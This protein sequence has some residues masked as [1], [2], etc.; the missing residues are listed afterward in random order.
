MVTKFITA[1]EAA[2]LKGVSR[3]AIYA[4][5]RDGRLTSKELL[6]RMAL[7]EA[8]VLAW[9]PAPRSGRKK[10][11]PMSDEAKLKISNGQRRRWAATR[12]S[13]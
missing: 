6:G 9:T 8:E 4:A 7:N 5:I 3:S 1:S 12:T 11:T 13:S 10:G 2:K